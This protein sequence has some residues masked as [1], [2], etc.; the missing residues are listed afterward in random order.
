MSRVK[1][2]LR[3][4][5][6]GRMILGLALLAACVPATA[7]RPA[8]PTTGGVRGRVRVGAGTPEGINVTVRLGE[9]EVRETRT[10]SKGEFELA[11]L[12]PGTYGLTF[13]K[14]GVQVGRMNVEIKAGKVVS[15]PKDKLF[16]PVDEGAIAFIRGSVFDAAGRSFA[17]A[18]VELELIRGDGT[19]KK[20][21]DRVTNGLGQFAFRMTPEPARYRVTAKADGME[22][23][24]AEVSVDSAAIF[25]VGLTL[26]RRK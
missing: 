12:A 16:L 8:Q 3:K 22:P 17:G 13:R 20:V 11:G 4:N 10:N 26:E 2:L 19:F 24:T 5:L 25:R 23:A 21:D 9:S 18:R 1:K 14:P 15:L 7:Q 6:W